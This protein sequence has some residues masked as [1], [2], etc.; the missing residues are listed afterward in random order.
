MGLADGLQFDNVNASDTFI[1]NI[2]KAL[3]TL[4]ILD[5]NQRK[6]FYD[7]V[8]WRHNKELIRKDDLDSLYKKFLNK[9]AIIA[10]DKLRSTVKSKTKHPAL[11]G[12][13]SWF[14]LSLKY[15]KSS[16]LLPII[17]GRVEEMI[18]L[19]DLRNPRQQGSSAREG[20]IESLT[21]RQVKNAFDIFINIIN[22]YIEVYVTK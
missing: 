21:E 20:K 18:G 7:K 2:Q 3:E 16:R 5:Y 4:F 11:K 10:P 19:S 13:L 1:S 6:I 8:D 9:S 14:I 17:Q 15:D 12:W 22:N